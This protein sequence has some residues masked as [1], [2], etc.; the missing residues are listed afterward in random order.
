MGVCGCGKSSLGALLAAHFKCK[1]VEGDDF[2]SAANVAKMRAGQPLEDEDRWPW[3][4][5]LALRLRSPQPVVMSCSALRKSY[6]DFLRAKAGRPLI[7]LCLTGPRSVLLQRLGAR[8]GHY[9]PASLLDSQLAVFESP[10]GENHVLMLPVEK[11]LPDLVAEA[12]HFIK[13]Y[14]EDGNVAS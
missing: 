4:E 6:R 12:V 14:E 9:M 3:L 13:K 7:F 8:Q 5:S 10:E 2:H 1:F 11:S